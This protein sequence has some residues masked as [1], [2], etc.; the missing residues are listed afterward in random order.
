MGRPKQWNFSIAQAKF[1]YNNAIH[2]ATSRSPFSIVYMKCHNHALDSVKLPKVPDN[3]L[4]TGPDM[5][6]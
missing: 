5:L 3:V 1:P 4:K 2:H 6:V